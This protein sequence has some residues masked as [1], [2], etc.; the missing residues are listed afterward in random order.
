MAS[1]MPPRL[2]SAQRALDV[3]EVASIICGHLRGLIAGEE[4]TGGS[5]N[6]LPLPESTTR[7]LARH[8]APV[9]RVNKAFY[10]A[11]TP[12]VWET[13]DT[14]APLLESILGG[15]R[16]DCGDGRRQTLVRY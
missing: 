4:I 7:V 11:S 3:V 13:I 5:K 15:E 14:L 16:I 8:L 1:P 10:S 9:A 12:H 6:L 2:S